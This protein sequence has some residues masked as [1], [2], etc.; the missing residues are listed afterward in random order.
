MTTQLLYLCAFIVEIYF[1][2]LP[3]NHVRMGERG[4]SPRSH[5]YI[6]LFYPVLDE[7]ESVMR[8]TFA[9]LARL[10]YLS[11]RFEV[12]VIPNASDASTIA[13]LRRMQAD[14]AFLQIRKV[15]PTTNPSWSAVGSA[16]M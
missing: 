3:I 5:P 11:D 16:S 9:A 2:Q 6:V 8:T 10:D 14:F 15:P 1:F 12:V 13:S 7:L 4:G